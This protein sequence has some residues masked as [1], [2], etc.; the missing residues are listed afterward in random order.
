MASGLVWG[1]STKRAR[2]NGQTEPD[3]QKGNVEKCNKSCKPFLDIIIPFQN[4]T[5]FCCSY[6]NDG[7]PNNQG[8]ED[9]A[10]I[11]PRSNPFKSWNDAPCQYEL[12][13]LCQMLPRASTS[14]GLWRKKIG[15]YTTS[16]SFLLSCHWINDC[17]IK[18]THASIVV[19]WSTHNFL[20]RCKSAIYGRT[21]SSLYP[22][23]INTEFV[24]LSCPG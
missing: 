19:C 16:S 24:S 4:L 14:T 15:F 18:V 1:T 20:S 2:G 17:R 3:W 23:H 7:E 5:H 9:C 8:N 11:Y 22:L 12:K 10:A 21:T 13:W 6:W